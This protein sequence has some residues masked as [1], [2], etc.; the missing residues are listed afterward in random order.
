MT[1]RYALLTAAT[2]L[3]LYCEG[4]EKVGSIEYSVLNRRRNDV[5]GFVVMVVCDVQPGQANV[6]FL[7]LYVFKVT[8]DRSL[9]VISQLEWD[10]GRQWGSGAA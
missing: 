7:P 9:P 2:L 5:E 8:P 4:V 1:Q 6:L 10:G 3:V